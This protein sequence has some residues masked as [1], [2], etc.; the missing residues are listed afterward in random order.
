MDEIAVYPLE[1]LTP[2]DLRPLLNESLSEGYDFIQRLWDDYEQGTNR[3]DTAGAILLGVFNGQHLIGVG[4]IQRDPYL[5]RPDVGRVRHVYILKAYR[6]QGVGKRL[7]EALI[8]HARADFTLLTLRTQTQSAAAFY[9]AS[10]FD[11]QPLFPDA[12][13][14]LRL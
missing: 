6:R 7:L 3:F 14:F 5:N 10:G 8:Q 4:G 12:T 9:V 2:E 1:K 11:D 13:H